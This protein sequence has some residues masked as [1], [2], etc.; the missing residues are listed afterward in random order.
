MSENYDKELLILAKGWAYG[1]RKIFAELQETHRDKGAK[2]C[3]KKIKKLG[4]EH[5]AK[6]YEFGSTEEVIK[7]VKEMYHDTDTHA[8]YISFQEIKYEE[9][10]EKQDKA[11]IIDLDL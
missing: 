10:L 3:R 8:K 1:H 9:F 11:N 5:L 6:I 2:A 7:R 4:I